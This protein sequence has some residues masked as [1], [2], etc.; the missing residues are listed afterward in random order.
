MVALAQLCSVEIQ[1]S[2]PLHSAAAEGDIEAITALLNAGADL[3]AKDEWGKSPIHVA[4]ENGRAW[5]IR[6]LLDAGADPD[7]GYGFEGLTPLQSAT[8]CMLTRP[9]RDR[10]SRCNATSRTMV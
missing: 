8:G 7:A 3:N 2:A 5:A 9:R 10:R 4:A 1:A 6:A